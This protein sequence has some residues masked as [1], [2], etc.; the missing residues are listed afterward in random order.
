MNKSIMYLMM[1]FAFCSFISIVLGNLFLGIVVMLFLVY[2][3][4]NKDCVYMILAK[5]KGY[6][7]AIGIFIIAMFFSACFS[8][9]IVFGL[10]R[11]LDMWIWRIMPFII[12]II[13]MN[14]YRKAFNVLQSACIGLLVGIIYIIYQGL[15]GD[16]RAAGFFGHAMTFAGWLCIFMPIF[17]IAAFDRMFSGKYKVIFIIL[18]ALSGIALIFNSTRGAWL[19]IAIVIGLLS[20][21]YMTKS[22]KNLVIGVIL[23]SFCACILVNNDNFVRRV[24]TI[25][26]NK[27]QSNAERLLMWKSAWNMFKDY[28]ILG[29]GLGQYKDNYQ[30]KYILPQ[31]KER[32]QQHAHSNFMQMLAENGIIGFLSFIVMF[33]YI[34]IMNLRKY[35]CTK[36]I[37]N[38]MIVSGTLGL[39]LHGFTEFNFGN[40][41]VVKAYWLILGCLVILAENVNKD[42]IIE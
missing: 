8:G 18:F 6:L 30:K 36:N 38:L 25:T 13:S 40:S 37:Y 3:Y 21:Y 20:I 27:Y 11:W 31:A 17:F 24:S 34:I 42:N 26:N 32:K 41:A 33:G 14:E 15:S 29:V 4:K 16:M 7:N 23:I 39:L 22:K 9:D 19:A 35:I 12:M 1:L 28:P 10:Q 2:V 5:N